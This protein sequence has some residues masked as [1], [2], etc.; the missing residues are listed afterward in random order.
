MKLSPSVKKVLTE[1]WDEKMAAAINSLNSRID[2]LQA[3]TDALRSKII[4]SEAKLTTSIAA[5]KNEAITHAENKGNWARNDARSYA[6]QRAQWARNDARAHADNKANWA[7]NDAR[8]YTD[9]RLNSFRVSWSKH[10]VVGGRATVN[11]PCLGYN[12]QHGCPP[13][14]RHHDFGY[15]EAGGG[16]R[17]SRWYS[18]I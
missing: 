9:Q 12:V 14:F 3:A 16:P 6:E 13:G 10:V 4:E 1:L 7:R 5:A 8:A 2:G 17:T 18:K 11:I 15:F